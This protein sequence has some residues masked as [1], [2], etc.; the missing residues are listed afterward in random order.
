MIPSLVKVHKTTVKLQLKIHFYHRICIG[1]LNIFSQYNNMIIVI[2]NE[3]LL[4]VFN[5]ETFYQTR[6]ICILF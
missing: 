3:Y 1:V 5:F 2:N 4:F 6:I